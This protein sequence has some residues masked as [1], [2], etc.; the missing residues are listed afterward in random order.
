MLR[1]PSP[2]WSFALFLGAL[3]WTNVRI[4]LCP[5]PSQPRSLSFPICAVGRFSTSWGWVGINQ[6]MDGKALRRLENLC[7]AALGR[8]DSTVSPVPRLGFAPQHLLT[9]YKSEPL[10]WAGHVLSTSHIS[11]L[12]ILSTE[13]SSFP[14]LNSSRCSRRS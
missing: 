8:Q 5:P 1:T 11:T 3:W 9:A 14:V 6:E 2:F 13:A 10:L 7:A 4:I 12:L